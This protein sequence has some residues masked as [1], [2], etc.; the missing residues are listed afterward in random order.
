MK[1]EDIDALLEN[2]RAKASKP[3]TTE[4]PT[5]PGEDDLEDLKARLRAGLEGVRTY[6]D[7]IADLDVQH[8]ELEVS[9][10]ASDRERAKSFFVAAA[11]LRAK[12]GLR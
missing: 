4:S 9:A 3:V 11:F 7:A 1:S 8:G 10:S 12:R 5:E 2:A 6:D